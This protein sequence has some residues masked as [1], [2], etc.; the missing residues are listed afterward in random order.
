[1]VPVT[2]FLGYLFTA[3]VCFVNFAFHVVIFK[4][5]RFRDVPLMKLLVFF[6]VLA[7][8]SIVF[9]NL[10]WMLRIAGVLESGMV[11]SSVLVWSTMPY[12]SFV[13][14]Y[15]ASATSLLIAR[16]IHLLTARRP[17]K[18]V[19]KFLIYLILICC[20]V[21]AVCYGLA[22]SVFCPYCI[23]RDIPPDCFVNQ[24]LLESVFVY[25]LVYTVSRAIASV[26][27]FIFSL[28]FLAVLRCTVEKIN[29]KSSRTERLS[30]AN[31]FLKSIA[32]LHSSVL[33]F[34]FVVEF[35]AASSAA[36]SFYLY[37]IFVN[38]IIR[39]VDLLVGSALFFWFNVRVT[40]VIVFH[41]TNT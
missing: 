34:T 3:V 15:N 24:C 41:P 33:I 30:K 22:F 10:L 37:I 29:T 17:R 28:V 23:R 11:T 12:F 32:L 20:V 36:R 2:A 16:I 35:A 13:S 31:Q 39:A 18:G 27:D 19:L 1:M 40:K 21:F 6:N 26:A 5:F 7:T 8:L 25:Q 14:A 4:R 9:S 38:K